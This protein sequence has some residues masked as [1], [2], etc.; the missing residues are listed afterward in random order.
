MINRLVGIKLKNHQAYK[1][2][3][4]H[5]FVIFEVE[6]NYYTAQVLLFQ[7]LFNDTVNRLHYIASLRDK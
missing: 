5:I 7:V 6:L 4:R 2:T 1:L 3:F